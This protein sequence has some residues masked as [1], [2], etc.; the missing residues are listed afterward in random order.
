MTRCCDWQPDPTVFGPCPHCRAM[1]TRVER[2][3]SPLI[4]TAVALARTPLRT[5]FGLV[6]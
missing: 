2:S 5:D 1:A 3:F 6:D 4:I